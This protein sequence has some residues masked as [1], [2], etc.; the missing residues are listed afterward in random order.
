VE[1]HGQLDLL[2]LGCLQRLG[3]AH[4]YALLAAIRQGSNGAFDLAEGT[5]YPA[6]H[7]LERGG[8]L[9]SRTAPPGRGRGRARRTYRLTHAGEALLA[10]RRAAWQAHVRAVD[11]VLGP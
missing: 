10:A 7:R 3:D 8:A 5:V 6:L 4:G 9:T 11:A 2:L 1:T